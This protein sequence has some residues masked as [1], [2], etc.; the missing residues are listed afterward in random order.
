[1]ARW[2]KAKRRVLSDPFGCRGPSIPAMTPFPSPDHRTRR[3]DLPHRALIQEDSRVRPREVARQPYKLGTVTYLR[4]LPLSGVR[5][6]WP[7]AGRVLASLL[8]RRYPNSALLF[9]SVTPS[10]EGVGK[11]SSR[12]RRENAW[13]VVGSVFKV[14]PAKGLKSQTWSREESKRT[15]D[16]PR[17]K[18]KES[19]T[20]SAPRPGRRRGLESGSSK[21][22]PMPPHLHKVRGCGAAHVDLGRPSRR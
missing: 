8:Q 5:L 22:A 13:F 9:P 14:W 6:P 21:A 3:A 12:H 7:V 16:Y 19:S 15:R 20:Y 4:S 10:S 17:Q 1:M 2:P 11:T 18:T